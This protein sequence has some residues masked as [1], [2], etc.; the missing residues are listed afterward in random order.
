MVAACN[1]E[2][3]RPS[4]QV[5]TDQTF[6]FF[7][8]TARSSGAVFADAQLR[9][10]GAA[11][12]PLHLA[13]GDSLWFSAGQ[14]IND[15][16][17]S[18]DIANALAEASERAVRMDERGTTDFDFLFLEFEIPDTPYYT[19]TLNPDPENRYYL[20]YLRGE[21]ANATGSRVS[22]PS[23][24]DITA[25]LSNETVSRANDIVIN[26]GTSDESINEADVHAALVCDGITR[27]SFNATLNGDTGTYTISGGTLDEI[28]NRICSLD[29]EI[30]K[31]RFG[32][33]DADLNGGEVS[34][35]RVTTVTIMSTD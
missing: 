4:D 22:L 24:F 21:L 5:G 8:V 23:P 2:E 7:S 25:P 18:S 26:W 30:T 20:G 34:G 29:I 32:V 28:T 31:R 33:L 35:Q 10:G 9:E 13:G 14:P 19:E 1:E 11:G 3:S 27:Q 16:E 12:T 15:F 17:A 6:V